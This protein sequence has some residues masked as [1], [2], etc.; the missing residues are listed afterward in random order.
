MYEAIGG[1]D[2]GFGRGYYEDF[3]YSLH[4]RKAGF[5][6]A[7]AEDAFVYHQG[8]AS[9]GAVSKEMKALIAANKRRVID[10]HG[11]D[12]VFPHVRDANLSVLRQY[13]DQQEAGSPSPISRIR[14]R[15]EFA[16]AEQPRSPLKRWRYSR[17]RSAVM[18]RFGDDL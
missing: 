10:R 18:C 7:V 14:N 5:E 17:R 11:A 4:A 3:D 13:A 16:N 12:T 8:S 1:L 9:F 15:M 6:L 2:E